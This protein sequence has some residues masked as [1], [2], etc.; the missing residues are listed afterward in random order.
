MEFCYECF[1]ISV[2][3]LCLFI[4]YK[5]CRH[6][7]EIR[8]ITEFRHQRNRT[9]TRSFSDASDEPEHIEEDDTSFYEA[10]QNN[11]NHTNNTNNTNDTNNTNN[12]NNTNE[13]RHFMNST[14]TTDTSRINTI[15]ANTQDNQTTKRKIRFSDDVHIIENEQ[16]E[17][18]TEILEQSEPPSYNEIHRDY[19][20]FT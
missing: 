10:E 15:T 11:T 3:F 9:P 8:R 20:R 5:A 19:H 1:G 6:D 14:S 12:T 2:T 7:I 13:R 16:E 4:L 17:D 18:Q